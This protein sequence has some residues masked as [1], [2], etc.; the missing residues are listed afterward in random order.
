MNKIIINKH[1]P[2]TIST[3]DSSHFSSTSD[4]VAKTLSDTHIAPLASSENPS[5]TSFRIASTHIAPLSSENP[6]VSDFRTTSEKPLISDRINPN[7]PLRSEGQGKTGTYSENLG[8]GAAG[9][10]IKPSESTDHGA[11]RGE[12]R[13]AASGGVD[14]KDVDVSGPGPKTL[15][16]IARKNGGTAEGQKQKPSSTAN[17]QG[18]KTDLKPLDASKQERIDEEDNTGKGSGEQYIKSSGVKAEGGDFDATKPGAGREADR[19]MG[20]EGKVESTG[21]GVGEW[22]NW[23]GGYGYGSD[24][25]WRVEEE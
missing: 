22:R 14:S 7:L 9:K 11:P 12:V 8:L 3:E 13:G 25:K 20:K 2:L 5:T 4:I 18:V 1:P 19:L 21:G 6:S 10:D 16:E 15:E 24:W 23:N 17:V